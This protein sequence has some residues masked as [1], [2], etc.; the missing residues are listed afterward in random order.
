MSGPYRTPS[1][2]PMEPRGPRW[3]TQWQKAWVQVM[4]KLPWTM[5]YAR[6]Q[7]ALWRRDRERLRALVGPM[8]IGTFGGI[9]VS[10]IPMPVPPPPRRRPVDS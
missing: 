10:G 9:R 7:C 1:P 4:R 6:W 2:I 8:W 3:A 5:A